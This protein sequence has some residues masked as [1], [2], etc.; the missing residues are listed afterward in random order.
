ML[1]SHLNISLKNGW[2]P[3]QLKEFIQVIQ[4]TIGKKDAKAA[5]VVLQEVLNP[6][7]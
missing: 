7:K 6:K 1:K 4:K 3:E 2:T 5:N